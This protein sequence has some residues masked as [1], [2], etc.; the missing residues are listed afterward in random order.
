MILFR[1]PRMIVDGTTYVGKKPLG[2]ANIAMLGRGV[3][4]YVGGVHN[5]S[6]LRSDM[7]VHASL[8]GSIH[9]LKI[10]GT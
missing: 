4:M 9:Q 10:S 8:I 3:R 7:P 6:Q 2:S 1:S 5:Q